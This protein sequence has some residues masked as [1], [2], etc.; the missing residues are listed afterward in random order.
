MSFLP[1]KSVLQPGNYTTPAFLTGTRPIPFTRN[2]P[3]VLPRAARAGTIH[4]HEKNRSRSNHR[5]SRSHEDGAA[6]E[7][8]PGKDGRL[9]A[10]GQLS[11]GRADLPSRQSAAPE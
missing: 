4:L 6:P 1:L 8:S 2:S 11:L 7:G 10:G 3:D 9:V 5:R